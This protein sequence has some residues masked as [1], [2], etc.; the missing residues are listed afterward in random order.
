MTLK[1]MP[2]AC[3]SYMVTTGT[4]SQTQPQCCPEGSNFVIMS[5]TNIKVRKLICA[6]APNVNAPMDTSAGNC[7]CYLMLYGL[8]IGK[9]LISNKAVLPNSKGNLMYLMQAVF[10]SM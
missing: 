3:T 6:S 5:I 8:P 2:S 7:C 9:S 10:V 1:H 4:A